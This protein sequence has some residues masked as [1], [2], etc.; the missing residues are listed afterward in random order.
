MSAERNVREDRYISSGKS[1][2]NSLVDLPSSY[3]DEN[4]DAQVQ[5]TNRDAYPFESQ[6]G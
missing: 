2:P 6:K 1:V 5:K 4:H 3:R